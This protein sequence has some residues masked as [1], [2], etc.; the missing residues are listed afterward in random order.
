MLRTFTACAALLALAAVALPQNGGDARLG[1][2]PP[3]FFRESGSFPERDKSIDKP[4]LDALEKPVDKYV[5]ENVPLE[6]AF[7]QFKQLAHVNIFV[8]WAA[9]ETVGVTR[10][11]PISIQLSQVPARRVLATLLAL[12]S[13]SADLHFLVTDNMLAISTR[14][15]LHS[16]KYQQVSVYDVRLLFVDVEYDSKEAEEIAASF[17]ATLQ[18]SVA[19]DSWRDAGGAVGSAR[20]LNGQLIINQS[21]DVQ[22]DVAA[23]VAQFKGA[24]QSVTRAY[25]VHDIVKQDLA[26]ADNGAAPNRMDLLINTIETTCGRG[27][28]R[29]REG[30]SSSIAA[31]DG[32]LF[33][34]TNA[35]VHQQIDELLT[36]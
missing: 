21:I 14:E 18:S 11:G 17:I 27:T 19:P 22:I 31:F 35:A 8:N 23:F 4:T 10:R 32:K 34:R 9:L 26:L 2:G 29:N 25:D 12:A 6:D 33:I 5:L 13:P 1:N 15:D 7:E 20:I 16:A 30:K 3:Q 28:W 24:T 36:M